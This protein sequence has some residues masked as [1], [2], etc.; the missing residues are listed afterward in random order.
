MNSAPLISH[1]NCQV[2]FLSIQTFQSEAKLN[3]IENMNPEGALLLAPIN[4]PYHNRPPVC[5]QS[6]NFLPPNR[7]DDRKVKSWS[8]FSTEPCLTVNQPCSG[9]LRRQKLRSLL[10][11]VRSGNLLQF[12]CL[13]YFMCVHSKV[14]LYVFYRSQA[15]SNVRDI[16]YHTDVISSIVKLI[17]H[18]PV[19]KLA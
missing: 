8:P 15:N 3:C 19:G 14:T 17:V 9:I 2:G 10:P 13:F 12:V 5:Q 4:L 1:S 16:L 18:S 7:A 6:E 11:T